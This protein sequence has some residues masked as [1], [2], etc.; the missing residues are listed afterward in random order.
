MNMNEF[1]AAMPKAELHM[2]IEG[3][4]SAAKVLE[5]AERNGVD[6][7]YASEPEILA[8]QDYGTPALENFLDYHY[9]CSSVLRDGRDV[10]EITRDFLNKCLAENIRHVEMFF[11]PQ[12][13]IDRGV[14]FDALMD[15][16]TTA[17]KA[18]DVSTG[19]IM[20][21]N[22]DRSLDSAMEML[23]L[24]DKHRSNIIGVGLDSYEED[25]P[26]IKF[27]D[28]YDRAR[29]EGY[30]LTAHC[31]CDQKNAVE[32]ANQ[33]VHKLGLERIDH[34]LHVLD[35]PELIEVVRERNITLTMCPT[36]RPSDPEPRRLK[37]LRKMLD[38]GLPVCLNT[39][40]PEEFANRY[41][42]NLMQRVQQDG[43][44]DAEDMT[45]FMRNAFRGSWIGDEQ[46]AAH[47]EELEAHL[48]N[49]LQQ[50]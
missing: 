47:L 26:P 28:F 4:V 22:R 11:D 23:D 19:L 49:Y 43:G 45:Q 24:A 1:I 30:R 39:D 15:A 31:D 40:D 16:M 3:T 27:Q 50:K 17:C 5:L 6:I 25:N 29:E 21:M 37:A 46:R 38:L 36:W 48:A 44:F 20:C 2:H 13:H 18:S 34:G 35:D 10:Y 8:A 7:P 9:M 41:L 12:Q 33:C 14:S 42:T 32:H